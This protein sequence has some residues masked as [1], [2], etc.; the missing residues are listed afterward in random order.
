MRRALLAI[1]LCL[2]LFD[3]GDLGASAGAQEQPEPPIP[4][5]NVPDPT[6]PPDSE[7]HPAAY[8]YEKRDY[9]RELV[10]RPMTLAEDQA[11]IVLDVPFVAGDGHPTLTQVLRGSFG[12]TVDLQLGVT[13]S[14][15]LERLNAQTGEDGFEAGKAFS[16][17]AAYTIIPGYLAAQVR[18]AFYADPDLFGLGLVLGVPFKLTFAERWQIFGGADLVTIKLKGLAVYP[19]D[20]AR[21][22]G[23]AALDARGG[24]T[25]SG[26]VDVTLGV[27]FQV[28]QALAVWG[29]VGYGWPDFDTKDQPFGLFAGLTYSPRRFWDLGARLG[30]LALDEPAASFSIGAFAALRM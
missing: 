29:T 6:L 25:P 12:V 11:E 13:Y 3:L 21:N 2:G 19:S 15:G 4:D 30:F 26:S 24:V 7:A 9:P 18:L 17:D 10:R 8:R 14:V 22:L 5:P 16:A 27:A 23:A 20:P 28:Q 1:P